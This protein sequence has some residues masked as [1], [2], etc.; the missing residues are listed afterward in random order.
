[1]CSIFLCADEAQETF[2]RACKAYE[3]CDYAQALELFKV[4]D[5]SSPAVLLNLGNCYFH[6][7]NVLQARICWKKAQYAGDAEVF[8][9]AQYC[10]DRLSAQDHS[11]LQVIGSSIMWLSKLMPIFIWQISVLSIFLLLFFIFLYMVG[12]VRMYASF[13]SI[14]CIS[15][16]MVVIGKSF[17]LD[18]SKVGIITSDTS[19]YIGPS[20][21]LNSVGT[22]AKEVEVNITKEHDGWYKIAYQKRQGWIRQESVALISS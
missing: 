21:E 10:L 9:C 11:I 19:L 8:K 7:G 22:V 14:V 13:L 15:L 4:I 18:A 12:K 5:P 3:A 17:M 2:L 1:M 6:T 16:C 20:H